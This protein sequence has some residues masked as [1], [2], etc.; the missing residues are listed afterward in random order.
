MDFDADALTVSD[1][2]L[3]LKEFEDSGHGDIIVCG[4][5]WSAIRKQDVRIAIKDDYN[6]GEETQI[7]LI[8]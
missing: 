6:T 3:L 4:F 2:I 1:L 5:G 7:L 8:E